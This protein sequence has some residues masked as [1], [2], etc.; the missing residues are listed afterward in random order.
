MNNLHKSLIASSAIAVS[1]SIG[2]VPQAMSLIKSL[3]F[4]GS[5]PDVPSLFYDLGDGLE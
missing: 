4:A 2:E 1:L 5:G 3:D